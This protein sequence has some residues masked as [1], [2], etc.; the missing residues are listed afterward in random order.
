MSLFELARNPEFP[1]LPVIP[2][3]YVKDYGA[4]YNCKLTL[5]TDLLIVIVQLVHNTG[6]S[7]NNVSISLTSNKTEEL[8]C[9]HCPLN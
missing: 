3:D 7:L 8:Y 2:E 4:K 1:S 6:T 9:F 5:L